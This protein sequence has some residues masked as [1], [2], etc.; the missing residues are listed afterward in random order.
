MRI[1]N[2]QSEIEAGDLKGWVQQKI[3]LRDITLYRVGE[4]SLACLLKKRMHL[5]TV[6]GGTTQKVSHSVFQAW[7]MRRLKSVVKF[8]GVDENFSEQG[9][10]ERTLRATAGEGVDCGRIVN[11]EYM[12]SIQHQ[13]LRGSEYRSSKGI[14]F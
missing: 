6:E 12:A 10:I 2:N 8:C 1:E 5:G 7:K 14:T 13:M 4:P 3:L 9:L 11:V